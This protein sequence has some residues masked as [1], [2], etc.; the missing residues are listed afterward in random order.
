LRNTH[1]EKTYLLTGK[2]AKRQDV[3]QYFTDLRMP[4]NRD[5]GYGKSNRCIHHQQTRHKN[6]SRGAHEGKSAIFLPIFKVNA[7]E[8]K[9]VAANSRRTVN[10]STN[11][12]RCSN[13][14][15]FN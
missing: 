15:T 11:R 4:L 1:L 9:G 2:E 10:E 5:Y 14:M 13:G 8:N 6:R 3:R 12:F 7:E